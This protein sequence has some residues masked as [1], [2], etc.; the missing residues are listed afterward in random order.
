[1]DR[2]VFFE[3][4]GTVKCPVLQRDALAEGE[5]VKGPAI[6]EEYASTTVLHPGDRATTNHF[7]CLSV[8][9]GGG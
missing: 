2:E 4:I 6:V 1:V 3:G 7:G 9:I 8:E 5:S